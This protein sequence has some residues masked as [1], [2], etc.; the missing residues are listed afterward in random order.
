MVLSKSA[1]FKLG[2]SIF[3][4][5]NYLENTI[6]Q[7]LSLFTNGILDK[8]V[9]ITGGGA[10]ADFIR[11]ADEE[12]NLGDDL[13]HWIAIF[14]MDYNVSLIHLKYPNISIT[15]DLEQ[16]K[17]QDRIITFFLP[18]EYIRKINSLSHSWNI[19][20]DSI[21]L[22]LAHNLELRNC[23]LIKDVDGIFLSDK[24]LLKKI[25]TQE[26][27]ELKAKNALAKIGK[28]SGSMKSTP[29]DQYLVTL[30]DEFQISCT[31]LNGSDHPR[32]IM[33]YL[34]QFI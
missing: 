21:A 7:L 2:G 13:S 19:T 26:Y 9:I 5:N 10:L 16:I 11:R 24:T 23:S 32:I 30:I 6:T 22:F 33:D 29:I 3:Q 27:R 28:S 18:Y 4:N 14:S 15:N 17:N 31:I 8:V 1:I 34:T 12:I 20:S 25:T